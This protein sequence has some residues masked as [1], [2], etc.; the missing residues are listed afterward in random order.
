MKIQTD[1]DPAAVP[2]MEAYETYDWMHIPQGDDPRVQ[3]EDTERRIR[4]VVDEKLADKGFDLDTDQPDFL[5]GYH[6][7]LR[8][9]MSVTQINTYYGYGWGPWYGAAYGRSYPTYYEEG[10][11]VLDV[12]DFRKGELV[13]RGSAQ[14]EIDR[15][16]PADQRDKQLREAVDRILRKFPPR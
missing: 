5:I 10:S 4:A 15:S 8:G 14:A 12:V 11:L 13:W 1:Y 16:R 7:A 3:N 9:Q 2:T 6:V